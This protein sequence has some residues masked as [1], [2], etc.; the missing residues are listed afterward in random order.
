MANVCFELFM[1]VVLCENNF[2]R[3]FVYDQVS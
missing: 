3:K 1:I 2:N